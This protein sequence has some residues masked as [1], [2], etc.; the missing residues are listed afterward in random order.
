VYIYPRSVA[1]S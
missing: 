1:A